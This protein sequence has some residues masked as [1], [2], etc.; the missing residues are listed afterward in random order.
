MGLWRMYWEEMLE[1]AVNLES[2]WPECQA[3]KLTYVI[4]P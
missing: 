4:Q 1:K 2:G 3:R